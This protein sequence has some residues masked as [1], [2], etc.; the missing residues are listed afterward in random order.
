M[1]IDAL[2]GSITLKHFKKHAFVHIGLAVAQSGSELR[3]GCRGREFKSRRPDHFLFYQ[4]VLNQ[5]SDG[6]DWV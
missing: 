3:W 4:C 2:D 1:S 6:S 5:I